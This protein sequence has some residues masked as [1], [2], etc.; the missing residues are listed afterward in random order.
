MG[1]QAEAAE[2]G[3]TASAK[4]TERKFCLGT[5]T[6]IYLTRRE[7]A[8]DAISLNLGVR[9]SYR[10]PGP[11]PIILLLVHN[12]RVVLSRSLE[13]ARLR[14]N[15]LSFLP[16]EFE[17]APPW[18]PGDLPA[19]DTERPEPHVFQII[20]PGRVLEPTGPVH[21]SFQVHKPSAD[22]NGSELLG[23]KVFFQLELD[24]ALLAENIKRALQARW[25][26]YGALWAYTIRTPPVELDIP[27]SPTASQCKSNT[28]I[29]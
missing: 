17:P 5:P 16:S 15:Q 6:G 2:R 29:D 18:G 8:P 28:V 4:I 19:L 23:K 14:R 1:A 22:G 12:W 9:L 3:L 10:N 25:R 27:Q 26:S 20:L 11:D 13:D 7:L 24:H 21:I